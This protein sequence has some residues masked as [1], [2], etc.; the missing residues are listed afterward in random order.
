MAVKMTLLI[1]EV[2]QRFEKLKTKTEKIALLHQH[3]SHAL[4]SVLR[5]TFDDAV[6]WLLPLGDPP[7]QPAD[8][9]SVPSNLLKQHTK[10]MYFVKGVKQAEELPAFKR[11]RIFLDM[12]ESIHPEDAQVLL[13]MKDKKPPAKGLTKKLVQEA[14]PNLV[15]R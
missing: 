9:K 10:L 15:S 11:E 4:Q 14:F 1:Y 13:K 8:I 6:Q 2:F 12:L 5:G 3:N 7:Y